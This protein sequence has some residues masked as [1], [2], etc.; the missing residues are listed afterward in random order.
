MKVVIV[1]AGNVGAVLAEKL[2]AQR[3]DVI[4][5]DS[6]SAKI[7]AIKQQLDLLACCGN[8]AN[9]VLLHELNIGNADFFIAVSDSDEI[10]ILSAI[11]ISRF[12]VKKK[13]V[14]VNNP[15]YF[16]E[17]YGFSKEALGIDV[18]INPDALC[19]QEIFR[20]LCEREVFEIVD[21]NKGKVK[22]V[23]IN[24]SAANPMVGATLSGFKREHV[25]NDV[26]CIAVCRAEETLIPHG[27]FCFQEN[28]KVYVLGSLDA[29]FQF[30]GWL[31][32]KQAQLKKVVIGGMNTLALS[33]AQLLEAEG[34]A[35]RLIETEQKPAEHAAVELK[36]GR[37]FKGDMTSL[38]ALEEAGIGTSDA[39]LALSDDDENNIL[40]CILAKKNG[41]QKSFAR[42][43]KIEYIPIV[44]NIPRIHSIVSTRLTT[45]NAV[46]RHIHKED[47]VFAQ[48]LYEIDARVCEV[49]LTA[50]SRHIGEAVRDISFPTYAIIGAIIREDSVVV[51][52]GSTILA[53][54]D[55]LILFSLYADT[56]KLEAFFS[57]KILGIF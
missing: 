50:N 49:T 53:K 54:D 44:S 52:T 5:I 12:N 7:D 37:V 2:C 4:I 1:G 40:A 24:L 57:K 36:H 9:P 39:F 22:L 27:D 23:G 15:D 19:S 26:C 28:D 43:S 32:V 20:L 56:K 55:R 13:I 31:G 30:Q 21:G 51:V 14:R 34:I 11:A 18:V 8:G 16:R 46:L 33:I 38:K 17:E 45:L 6:D 10:N 3:H 48:D 42:I 41:A 25:W 35:V 47:A 29:I